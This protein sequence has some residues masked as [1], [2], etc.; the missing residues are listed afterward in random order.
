[1]SRGVGDKAFLPMWKVLLRNSMMLGRELGLGNEII[2]FE[3]AVVRQSGLNQPTLTD[4]GLIFGRTTVG[5]IFE[6]EI[7]VL[8]FE[9]A[10][11]ISSN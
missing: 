6:S 9:G 1:M 10:Y 5:T 11:H 4:H 3:E 7:W 8:A 2:T